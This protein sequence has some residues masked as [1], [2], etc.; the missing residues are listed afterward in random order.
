PAFDALVAARTGQQWESRGQRGG[1]IARLAGHPPAHPDLEVPADCWVAAP[2]EGPLFAGIPWVSMGAGYLATLAIAAA[3]RA[4][5]RTGAMI[6]T[7]WRR[8]TR[9]GRP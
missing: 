9:C 2:R 4:R 7:A 1:T 3:L 6:P 8:S 5:G